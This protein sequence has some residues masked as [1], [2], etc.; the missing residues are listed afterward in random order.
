M[1]TLEGYEFLQLNVTT[2]RL[3]TEARNILDSYSHVW[4][5]LAESLQNSVDAVEDGRR[6]N[7]N[8]EAR[9]RIVFNARERAIE[10]SDTGIGMSP[11]QVKNVLAPHEGLKRGK[12]KRGEKGVGLS[13]I[14]FLSN[15]FRI[16]TCDG[17][18]TTYLEIHRANDWANGT[19]QQPLKFV[20]AKIEGPNS[21][22]NNA[23][24]TRIWAEQIP[25]IPTPEDDIFEYTKPRL[26][27]ILQTKTAI[28]NTYPLFHENQRP[29]IDIRCELK[30]VD[31]TGA[32]GDYEDI[33]YT[34][35]TPASFLK[36]KD[37]YTFEEFKER[38]VQ[39]KNT[40]SKGLVNV[41]KSD[42][43]SGRKVCWY[44]FIS[45]RP[46]FDEISE[47]NHLQT[48]EV[49]DV[50]SGIY[51]STRGMPT[52][53][54]L[55]PPR[56]QQASYWPSFFILLEYDDLRLDMGRKFVGGRVAQMLT[57]V[58]ADIFNKHVNAVPRLTTKASDPFDGLETDVQ[59]EEIKKEAAITPELEFPKISYFRVPVNEQ[60][61]V[62]IFH[63]LVGAGLL[64]GYRTQRSSS[65]DRY[66]A[67]MNYKPD[68][69]IFSKTNKKK[70]T[71]ESYNFFIE[72]KYEAGKSLLEDFDIRKRP[73]D[74][75]LLICWTL[76]KSVFHE[77]QID[78]VEVDPADT[79][80]HGATHKLVF[81]NSYGFGAEN[82]LH[83]IALKDFIE[84]LK[85][86]D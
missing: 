77:N 59:I 61:V 7:A 16:E 81:P 23:T 67:Y 37:V 24:Y 49:K 36:E 60:G 46:T 53:I 64:K 83:V 70:T 85:T 18:T 58:A 34:Y 65:Y 66:D 68:P 74:F 82:T 28:G 39:S 29:E 21:Y 73:R 80:F 13:F 1:D 69:S 50:D 26:R 25:A 76:K 51:I 33:P 22:L 56:S 17:N 54:R 5:I 86:A 2:K 4:D 11:E 79:I 40:T 6:S 42:T 41:G 9:I 62:A 84:L 14:M 10:V 75:R 43:A 55:A 45:Q 44:T 3:Q 8:S 57:K 32:E 71:A 27:Y 72:F 15:R 78:V 52:G 19:E 20:K 38:L 48:S 63:E 30:Y 47:K 12:K 35:A 31:Q